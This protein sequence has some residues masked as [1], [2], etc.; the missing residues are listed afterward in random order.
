MKH[1]TY[2]IETQYLN[3]QHK[4]SD[5]LSCLILQRMERVWTGVGYKVS[6]ELKAYN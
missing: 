3:P 4:V 6:G 1:N 5:C 2:N